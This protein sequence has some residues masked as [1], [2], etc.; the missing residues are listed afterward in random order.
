MAASPGGRGEARRARSACRS[1]SGF[2]IG[3]STPRSKLSFR[4]VNGCSGGVL[5]Y[6]RQL[7]GGRVRHG[8]AEQPH[9]DAVLGRVGHDIDVVGRLVIV[10]DF[11]PD[12][13]Y[14]LPV[15]AAVGQRRHVQADRPE[16]RAD[17]AFHAERFSEHAAG[18]L[19]GLGAV[20][21]SRPAA[22]E[23]LSVMPS[24]SVND[25]DLTWETSVSSGSC[26]STASVEN[27][28]GESLQRRGRRQREFRFERQ[29]VAAREADR[30]REGGPRERNSLLRGI[31]AVRLFERAR[32][33]VARAA[34]RVRDE[35]PIAVRAFKDEARAQQRRRGEPLRFRSSRG[36]R[37]LPVPRASLPHSTLPLISEC[38]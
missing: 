10:R 27:S 24:G 2:A 22:A 19:V 4:L 26:S 32:R 11:G 23:G 1:S 13:R 12:A 29:G 15:S 20:Q 28:S 37:R 36:S 9:R 16:F 14:T 6:G 7:P 25:A 31:R 18:Y 34:R 38:E 8:F 30:R 3:A 21:A 5:K 17:R 33:Q 35:R